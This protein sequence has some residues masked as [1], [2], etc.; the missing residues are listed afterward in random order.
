M[1]CAMPVCSVFVIIVIMCGAGG[2]VKLTF[3]FRIVK[4]LDRK[5]QVRAHFS[6]KIRRDPE[7]HS[8]TSVHRKIR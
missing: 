5:I 3:E 1:A 2:A 6:S 4:H 8:I 7:V